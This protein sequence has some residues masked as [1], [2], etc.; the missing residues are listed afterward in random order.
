MRM[1]QSQGKK[2]KIIAL[3]TKIKTKDKTNK[4][5]NRRK[6]IMKIAVPGWLS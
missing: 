3:L 6:K 1:D 2:R 5:K 4:Q